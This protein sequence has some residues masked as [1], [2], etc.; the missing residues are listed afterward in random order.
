MTDEE[1]VKRLRHRGTYNEVF[2]NAVWDSTDARIDPAHV[3]DLINAAEPIL[4]EAYA[5][6]EAE[7]AKLRKLL[8]AIVDEYDSNMHGPILYSI[9]DARI[10]LLGEKEKT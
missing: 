9:D 6:S 2:D 4:A 3:Q 1:L 7:N 10:V 5:A 8:D